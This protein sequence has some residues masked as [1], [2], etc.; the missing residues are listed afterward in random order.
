MT[1]TQLVAAIAEKMEDKTTKTQVKAFLEALRDTASKTLSKEGAFVIPDVVK[2]VL[3]KTP[4]RPERMARNPATGAP[5][6]VAAK[7]AGKKLKARFV[8]HLKEKVGQVAPKARKSA[9]KLAAPRG[10]SKGRDGCSHRASP[11]PALF[12]NPLVIHPL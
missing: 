8:K 5:I 12:H 1:K 6:K 2:L 3:V 11:G 10:P 9:A 7:P 4:A